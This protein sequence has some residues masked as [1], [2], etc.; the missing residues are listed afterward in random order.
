MS[1][2]ALKLLAFLAFTTATSALA[3]PAGFRYLGRLTKTS[4]APVERATLTINVYT[5]ETDGAPMKVI[6]PLVDRPLANGVFDLDLNFSPAELDTLLGGVDE[7][8]LE[9]VADFTEAGGE[10]KHV[11]MPRQR[12]LASPYSLRTKIDGNSLYYDIDGRLTARIAPATTNTP[13]LIK[14]TDT[15][16]TVAADGTITSI[17]LAETAT[18]STSFTGTMVGDVTGTQAATVVARIQG[19]AVQTGTPTNGQILKWTTAGGG[20]WEFAADESGLSGISGGAGGNI[21]DDTITNHDISSTAAIS[22]SKLGAG[23]VDDTELGYLNGVTSS[24][25]TQLG[26]KQATIGAATNI[27][28]QDLTARDAG[29]R[30]VTAETLTTS[31]QVAIAVQPYAALPTSTG[32]LRFYELTATGAHYVALKAADDLAGAVT[33]TLP[34]TAGTTG[35][36]LQTSGAGGILTWVDAGVDTNAKTLCNDGEYLRGETTTTCRTAAQIV[37]DGGAGNMTKTTYDA[38]DNSK[39]DVADNADL[40][41]GENA[42]AFHNAANLTG[43]VADARLSASVSLLGQTITSGEIVDLD[44]AKLTGSVADGRLSANVSLLGQTITSG[45]IVDL[46]AAKLTGSVADG[47]LSAN[48]SLLGQTI[49]SGEIVDGTIV[50]DDIAS[51]SGGKITAG[52]IGRAYLQTMTGDAG[53]GGASGAAPAPATGDAAAGKYLKADGTWAVPSATANWAAPGTI[54]STTPNTGAFTTLASTSATVTTS[55]DSDQTGVVRL[56]NPSLATA[57]RQLDLAIGHSLATGRAAHIGYRYE[58]ATADSGLYLSVNGDTSSSLFLRKG[59]NVG[60]GTTSPTSKLHVVGTVSSPGVGTGASNEVFGALSGAALTTGTDNTFLGQYAGNSVTTQSN[61][62]FVG[63]S[64]GKNVTGSYNTFLGSYA[65]FSGNIS[66]SIALGYAATP[67]ASS[68]L[69]VG[70]GA[71]S[72]ENAYLG[73]GVTASAPSSFTINAS[74]G[75][76]TDVAGASLAFAGGRA[77]GNAASGPI[78]FQTSDIGASGTT[79]QALSTKMTLT[80]TGNVGIGTTSPSLKLQAAGSVGLPA[81]TGTTQTGVMRYSSTGIDAVMDMGVQS[82]TPYGG[83]I[84]STNATDLSQY[85]AIALNPRGGA[86]GIGTP[87]PATK[88]DVNGDVKAGYKSDNTGLTIDWTLGNTQVTSSAAGTLVL[89]GM[90]NGGYYTLVLTAGSTSAYT[91]SGSSISTWKCQPACA[92]NQIIGTSAKDTVITVMKSGTIGYVTWTSGF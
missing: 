34:A 87:T 67:T 65:N 75:S 68:Q 82:V 57:G 89:N 73:Q 86:V 66:Q 19:N 10:A 71:A 61:N 21:T 4:G 81:T 38:G 11:V 52:T 85:Y 47:R 83:W 63:S 30:N 15:Y 45:E 72:V 26:T 92:S 40:L 42:A 58:T 33:L 77:T 32:E 37:A 48:V 20:R 90:Q 41:G 62:V 28:M 12:L 24:I 80:A 18:T 91:L 5:V 27:T 7:C 55:G 29:L 76:G 13:G 51:L 31:K 84:Q 64:S 22:A 6:G 35:Q 74:G 79:L 50:D 78:Y 69:V 8:W 56:L 25:Q 44:A 49:T 17:K 46:D 60:I 70:S 1:R 36:V 16:M 2:S 3:E 43:S 9:V 39:V 53:A 14:A 23:T 59:G 88:L 54:G